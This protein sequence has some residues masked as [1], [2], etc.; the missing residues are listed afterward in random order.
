MPCNFKLIF[1]FFS[2]SLHWGIV[3][4]SSSCPS[5]SSNQPQAQLFF[6]YTTMSIKT[7]NPFLQLQNQSQTLDPFG[8]P[9]SKPNP[10]YLITI[11][12]PNPMAQH[13]HIPKSNSWSYP[14]PKPN[15][16]EPLIIHQTH[17]LNLSSLKIQSAEPH[18][19]IFQPNTVRP[20]PIWPNPNP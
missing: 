3:I 18:L 5:P 11:Q 9:S 20:L 8:Q 19:A 2:F 7:L 15:S 1:C 4:F 12:T 13:H 16:Q 14:S 10:L 6:G 17:H